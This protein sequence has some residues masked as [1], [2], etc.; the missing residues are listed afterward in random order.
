MNELLCTATQTV[1]VCK[2]FASIPLRAARQTG[3]TPAS[4]LWYSAVCR[5]RKSKFFSCSQ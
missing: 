3:S 1:T 2:A 5:N 4:P